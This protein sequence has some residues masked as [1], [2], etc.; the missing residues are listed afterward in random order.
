VED[1]IQEINQEIRSKIEKEPFL[2]YSRSFCTFS[3]QIKKLFEKHE[4]KFE[5][6]ELDDV[7]WGTTMGG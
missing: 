1:K 3:N 2:M 7:K 5:S 6:I 4:V